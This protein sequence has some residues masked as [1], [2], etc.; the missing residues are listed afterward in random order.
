M[1]QSTDHFK[2]YVV[3]GSKYLVGHMLDFLPSQAQQE[4]NAGNF[5]QIG[6][7][8]GVADLPVKLYTAGGQAA[9]VPEQVFVERAEE[10]EVVASVART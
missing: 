7:A 9:P 10:R 3:R 2:Y 4:P 1:Y 6:P 5:T 8:S